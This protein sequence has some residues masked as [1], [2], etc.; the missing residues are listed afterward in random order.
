MR[1]LGWQ[2]GAKAKNKIVLK[3]CVCLFELLLRK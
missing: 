2:R 1:K 3:F